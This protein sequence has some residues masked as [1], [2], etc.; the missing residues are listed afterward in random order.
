MALS[1]S[2][3]LYSNSR[4]IVDN[5]TPGSPYTTVQSAI[6]AAH[7]AGGN[8]DVWIRQGT[9][10]ENLTLYDT[11]NVEGQEQ[12]LSI[13]IGHHTPP[14]SGSVR[15][16][17]VGLQAT[18]T[19]SIFSSAVAGSTTLNCL[20]CQFTINNGYI[21]NLPNWTGQLVLRWCVDL[22]T[23]N[24]IINNAGGSA[25][26]L[27]HSLIGAGTGQTFTS[28]GNC[29]IFS[30][31]FGCPS[32]FNGTGTSTID[33]A[34][35][36]SGNI[37]TAGSHT[38]RISVARIPTGTA[39]A[40][41]HNSSSTLLV[42]NAVVFSTNATAIGGSGAGQLQIINV[43]FP[44]SNVIAGTLTLS[45]QGVTKTAE[46]WANNIVRMDFAGFYSWASAGPYYDVATLGTFKLL[47]GGTGYIGNKVVTWVPQNFVGMTA[48]NT[49]Y[50]YIDSTGTIGATSTRTD[51]LFVNNIVLFECLRDSTVAGN[52]QY[53]S[54]ENHPYDFPTSASNYLHDTAGTVI[55][56]Y[57]KGANIVLNGSNG[58]QINGA[59]TLSDHGLDTA[60]PD[61]G[62][63]AVTWNIM[64]TLGSGKWA[65][66]SSTAAFPAFYNNAGTPTASSS[67]FIYTLYVVKDTLNTTTPQYFAVM[68][69]AQYANVG[70]AQ[71]ALAN[72]I[73]AQATGELA[74]LEV[75]QLGQIIMHAAAIVQVTIAK[76]TLRSVISSS[77]TNTAALVSTSVANFNGVLSSSDTNVQ[78]ALETIDEYRGGLFRST[79]TGSGSLLSNYGYIVKNATPANL[80]TLTLPA[81]PILGDTIAVNGYTSG[82]WRIAQNAGQ[83]IFMGAAATTIGVGGSISSTGAKDAIRITCVTAGASAEW[84]TTSSMG[85][86]T[87]V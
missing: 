3:N 83:Q 21:Y 45:L 59:D 36:M 52:I 25:I 37:A 86:L 17:R 23:N 67:Y 68:D 41:T 29:R 48:G 50:I 22:S 74:Q 62:G 16:T 73:N 42:E 61:S 31:A 38:L 32:L 58:I 34:T 5:V 81:T 60:I 69:T 35:T 24:G 77:G 54:K 80:T 55:E 79:A 85:N 71:T 15:F 30:V 2:T 6:N 65:T 40:I 87:V 75:C 19:D 51:A 72:G 10:T 33:G 14:A 11:V 53:V 84:V 26:I 12:T 4:Y 7:A 56:N 43:Q 70:A 63:A 28:N 13:I 82:G 9:Y 1:N 8:A 39:Q 78:T 20:R 49:Y 46:V 64:Y 57:N 27:N 47:V 44:S 76:S 66:Y 18:G